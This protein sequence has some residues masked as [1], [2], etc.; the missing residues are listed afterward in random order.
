MMIKRLFQFGA[1]SVV[2]GSCG[3]FLFILFEG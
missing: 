3:V 1:Y 2:A